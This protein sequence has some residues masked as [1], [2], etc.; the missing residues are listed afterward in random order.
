MGMGMQNGDVSA[1]THCYCNMLQRGHG[2]SLFEG[3]FDGVYS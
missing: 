1:W 3:Y 2:R